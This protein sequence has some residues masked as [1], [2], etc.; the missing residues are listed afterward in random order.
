MS[1][2]ASRIPEDTLAPS[3]G[4]TGTLEDIQNIQK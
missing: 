1:T 3:E 2:A 4:F